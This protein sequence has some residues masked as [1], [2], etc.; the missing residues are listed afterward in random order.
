MY[1]NI[2]LELNKIN[3]FIF[4]I[5]IISRY[6]R[7]RQIKMNLFYQNIKINLSYVNILHIQCSYQLFKFKIVKQFLFL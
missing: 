3:I 5:I 1:S 6:V 7:V 2:I 4:I